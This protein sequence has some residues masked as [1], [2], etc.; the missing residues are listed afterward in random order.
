[1]SVPIVGGGVS[2]TGIS[3]HRVNNSDVRQSTF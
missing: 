1:L 2:A 3:D